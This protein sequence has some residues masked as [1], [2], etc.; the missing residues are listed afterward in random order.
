M[1][2]SKVIISNFRGIKGGV[3]NL[4]PNT[5][6]VGDNNTGK[7]T[8][9]EAIDLVLGPDRMRR[10]PPINEHDFYAGDYL[11]SDKNPIEIAIEV[12]VVDINDEQQRHF[13]DNI[14]WWDDD[15][16]QLVENA[17]PE[18][19]DRENVLP[20]L[21]LCFK[22]IYDIDED[23]F[24]GDTFFKLP[25]KEDGSLVPFKT[26]DKRVCGFLYLRTLRTGSRALSL[27]RG[28]LLDIILN[29]SEI[30]L[31]MWEETLDQIRDISV[32]ENPELGIS[33]ILSGIQDSLKSLVPSDWGTNPQMKVSDF[34]REHLRKTLNVFMSTGARN[35]NGEAHI[36]PFRKQ[37]T[38]TINTLVLSMLSI[39]ADLKQN[40]I[41][42]MEEP[43]IAIP[44]HTQK[45]IINSVI[46]KSSQSIFT[47]HSPYV[48]EEFDPKEIVVLS[49]FDG[50]VSSRYASFTSNI[51]R[52][53]YQIEFRK[54]YCEALLSSKVLIAEGKTEYDAIP[55]VARRLNR[56]K[57]DDYSSLEALGIAI[58][59][60]ET[61]SQIQ[62]I[63]TLLKSLGKKTYAIFDKQDQEQGSNIR[64]IVDYPYES[65]E[66]SFEKLL[67]NSIPISRFRIFIADLISEGEWPRHLP[68]STTLQESDDTEVKTLI[69]KYFSWSKGAGSAA[70]LLE[71]CNYEE[72]PLFIKESLKSIKDSIESP[73]QES[74][75]NIDDF[76][77]I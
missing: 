2:I 53:H 49:K 48:L 77:D 76:L 45:R 46:S 66:T 51:K 9:L 74:M 7:S 10:R 55:L 22:G 75:T 54:R 33:N 57:P 23:D 56:L 62:P 27:E 18:L 37:G 11:D 41:F 36:A 12:T 35:Q 24:I 8:V 14:E 1:R 17:T 44:P 40:V 59:D 60:A 20:A 16:N 5:V 72:I 15:S 69:G 26:K 38:G 4:S 73:S 29:L 47:S 50:L 64:S 71:S 58:I 32:A 13:K 61:D 52:K 34:T 3:I 6:I 63:A 31:D 39:I 68:F 28:S 42:A 65:P 67:M 25:I 21:R 43:E 30:K 19:V 70:L